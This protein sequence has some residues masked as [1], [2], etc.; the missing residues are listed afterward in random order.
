[1]EIVKYREL[2]LLEGTDLAHAWEHFGPRDELGRLNHLTPDVLLAARAEVRRGETFNLTIP[3]TLPDPKFGTTRRPLEH[4]IVERNH[5][6]QDDYLDTFYLQGSTQWDSLRH[7][8]TAALGLDAEWFYGRTPRSDL[9]PSGARLGI[10][11]WAQR[12]I[13]GRGVLAD[14]EGHERR[15]GRAFDATTPTQITVDMLEATLADQGT[16][17]RYGDI[18]LLRTG[19]VDRYLADTPEAREEYVEARTA[20]GLR[21]SAEM[22]EFLWDSGVV[23]IAADNPAVEFY[24]HPSTES[25]HVRLIPLLGFAI[26]EFFRFGPLAEDC[27]RDGVYSCFFAS[28]PLNVPGGVGSPGNAIAVK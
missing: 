15:I 6:V 2:P 26:G 9:E 18:L 20:P 7:M 17:L 11:H 13:V 1:M 19:Y 8:S 23:A 27:A 3:L 25:L 22:A 28:V 14:V 12:G 10:Q 24:P 5:G 16:E 21:G 4:H